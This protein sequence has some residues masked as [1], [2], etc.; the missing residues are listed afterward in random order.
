MGALPPFQA[1]EELPGLEK[2]KQLDLARPHQMALI[3]YSKRSLRPLLSQ[4]DRL[5][6][7]S[8]PPSALKDAEDVTMREL[9]ESLTF[10]AWMISSWQRKPFQTSV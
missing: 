2:G 3:C 9:L 10:Q 7:R 4:N 1:A 8:L 6:H 5:A